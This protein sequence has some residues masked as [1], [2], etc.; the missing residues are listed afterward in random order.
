MEKFKKHWEIQ[1]NWQLLFPFFGLIILAYSAF[2]I[3]NT[4]IEDRGII[5]IIIAS[6][7][8]FFTLLK[9]TLFLFKKLEKKW[10]LD[11]KWEMIRVFMVFAFTGSSSL[12]VG[13]PIIKLLGITKENL[14][15]I[16]YWFLFIIIG[17]VF[18]QILLVSFGWLFGQF[19]FFWEFEKKMLRRFGLKRFLD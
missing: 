10:I 19:K 11:Y 14:N 15:P 7:V 17:L 9:L 13:R 12:V 1:H 16:L 6:A 4:L 2:K 18:Y 5:V 3:S 8:L